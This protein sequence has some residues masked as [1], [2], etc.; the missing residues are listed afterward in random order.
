MRDLG[1]SSLRRKLFGQP[2]RLIEEG[3]EGM[4]GGGGEMKGGGVGG[5]MQSTTAYVTPSM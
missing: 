5:D 1:N 4:E 2:E 3:G